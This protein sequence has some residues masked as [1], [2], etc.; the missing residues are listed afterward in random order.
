MDLAK[1]Q[2]LSLPQQLGNIASE[3]SRAHY[4]EEKKDLASRN[5][6]L[7]RVLELIDLT[8]ANKRHIQRLRE[9]SRLREVV[10]DLLNQSA[11]YKVSLLEI[12]NLLLPFA[13]L[14]RR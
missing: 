2:K 6:S 4:W 10:A 14:A 1:W 7:E 11:I 9:I 8:L 13:L 3:I 5:Q 12:Q